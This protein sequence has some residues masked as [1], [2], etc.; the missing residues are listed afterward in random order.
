M[1]QELTDFFL[2]KNLVVNSVISHGSFGEVFQVFSTQYKTVFALKKIPLNKFNQDEVECVKAIDDSRIVS[3]YDYYIY[4]GN[5]YML[6]EFCPNDLE[7]LVQNSC[8][9]N[10]Y[11]LQKL[12][13]DVVMAI[14]SCHDR[15]IAHCDIKPANFMFDIYGRL[16]IGDFGFSV[17]CDPSKTIKNYKGTK[18]FMSPEVINKQSHDPF[19]AD[20]WS[21]GVT[22]YYIAT[23]SLPFY[24]RDSVSLFDKFVTE[25]F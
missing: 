4:E 2:S 6:M 23:S 13:Y 12:T 11:E 7:K 9:F 8:K 14:K 3:L 18:L 20:I 21:L 17:F 1:N 15:N 25:F 16:K 19:I 10:E 24:S 5:A 22:L